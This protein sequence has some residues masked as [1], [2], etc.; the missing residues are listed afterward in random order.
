MR[1]D[2]RTYFSISSTRI[3]PM[4]PKQR[5]GNVFQYIYMLEYVIYYTEDSIEDNIID[6]KQTIS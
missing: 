6:R 3:G 1:L 5:H 2:S 4:M